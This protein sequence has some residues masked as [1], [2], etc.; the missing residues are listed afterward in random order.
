MNVRTKKAKALIVVKWQFFSRC[1]M[2]V[3]TIFIVMFV[4]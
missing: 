1:V 3:C 4:V 2:F